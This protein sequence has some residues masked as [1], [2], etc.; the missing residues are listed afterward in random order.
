MTKIKGE[1]QRP[2]L[3][4]SGDSANS[5][6]LLGIPQPLDQLVRRLNDA[7]STST[8][9]LMCGDESDCGFISER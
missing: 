6:I 8:D 9:F 2:R 4:I 3:F 7:S 1:A 5:C